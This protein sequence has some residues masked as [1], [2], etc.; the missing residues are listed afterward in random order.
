MNLETEICRELWQ[1]VQRSYVSQAWSNAILD[2]VHYLSE[3]VRAKTGLQSDGTALAGQAL[4]SKSP[5]LRLNRLETESEKSI[6][7][8]MEQLFRGLYQA[9]RNPRSHE[10]TEDN[11]ADADALILFV[12]YLLRVIGHARSAFSIDECVGCILEEA[13]VPNLRYAGLIVEE[14]P[15]RQRLQ[16]ALTVYQRKL[17]GDGRQ[18]RYFFDAV[19]PQLAEEEVRDLFRAISVDLRESHDEDSLRCVLQTLNPDFWTRIDETAR[20]RTENRIIRILQDGRYV[21]K[22][23]KCPTGATATWSTSFWRHFSL[24][25]ELMKT[26]IEKLRSTS[27]ESQDYALQ[28][29]LHYI[30][31]LADKPCAFGK[32]A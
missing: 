31:S 3:A 11:Q 15:N 25:Q 26:I 2:S 5:K 18:L 8:E 6:Q 9:I 32:G 23:N 24:K 29:C 12:D 17:E 7:A 20:L 4:G 27:T 19:V 22:S 13:F 30:D 10:R 21:R 28:F 1:A 14:I 16:V